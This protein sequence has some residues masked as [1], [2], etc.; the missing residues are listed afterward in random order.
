M[1]DLERKMKEKLLEGLI[2]HMGDRMGDGLASKF[3]KKHVEVQVAAPDKEHLAEGLGKA[4]ELISDSGALEGKETP[5]EEADEDR[6]RQLLEEDE[7][8]ENAKGI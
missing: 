2:E 6:L 8:E 5:D 3:P 7:D 1:D 4:K